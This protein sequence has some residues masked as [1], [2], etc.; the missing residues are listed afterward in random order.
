MD[1]YIYIIVFK[2]YY[3]SLPDLIPSCNQDHGSRRKRKLGVVQEYGG[4][5]PLEE[6]YIDVNQWMSIIIIFV[7]L[8]TNTEREEI[9]TVKLT[10]DI[11]E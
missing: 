3:S 5:Y 4:N 7:K 2:A 9:E 1:I 8:Q 6:A 10:G 11:V